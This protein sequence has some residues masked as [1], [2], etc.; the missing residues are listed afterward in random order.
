MAL[1]GRSFA[2]VAAV[3]IAVGVLPAQSVATTIGAVAAAPAAAALAPS[4]PGAFV[5]VAPQRL[6]DTRKGV[7]GSGPVVKSGTVH[8]QVTGR[9][10]VPATGVS[11][12]VMNVTVTAPSGSGYITAYPDGTSLPTASNLNF[13]KGQTVPNLV[14]VKVGTNGKVALRN[15]SGGT[16][17]LIAD[18]AGYYLDGA[19]SV[20]GAFVA[21]APQRLLDTRKGVGGS[22]PVVKSGTVHLQVTGRGGVPA[23]GVSAVVMNVT[24]TAPSGSGYITAYPD[25]TSLP[26]ASNL[27]FVKGQTVPNLVTVKVGTN[28]KVALR[29]GSGGTVQ[30][31]A[32]VAGYY[33]DGAPSVPGAFVAVAPQRLLD[34]RKGVGGSGPVVKSGTVHLQVT[35]RGGVP[36]TG[37]SAV[38]MNVTVTAPSGSGYITAYPDGTSLPTASNLNF[39]KGQTVPNLVTVKVGTNGKVAL[40]NGSGGT[41]QLIADV[42]GYYLD[43]VVADTTAPG[44]V[45][46]VTVT[47][48]TSSTVALSWTNPAD[49][50]LQAVMVRRATG[51]TAPTSP[52]AGTLVADVPKGTT[53]L[54][55]TA[56]S[57]ATQYSYA[58][59]A[60]DAVPNYATAASKTVS[61]AAAADTTPPAPVTSVTVT[62]T[63]STSV[64]M[65]WT[66]PADTD[67]Q[68]VMVRRATGA[69]A[70]TSPT[71]GTLVADVPK[72]TTTLTDTALSPATQ[73]SY[74]FFAHDA[75]PN[76]AS[77]VTKSATTTAVADTT[78][79]GP[80]TTVTLTGTTSSSVSLSWTNPADA[81][82]QAVMVRRATGATA[83][84]SPTAGTLVADVPK[85]TT[86]LT[87]T[88]LSPATPYSYAFFAHDAVPNYA[89]PVAKTATTTT[90]GCDPT[91]IH[92]GGSLA[93]DTT[94]AASQPCGVVYVLD[95]D[96]TIE[97]EVTLTINQGGIVKAATDSMLTVAGS[98]V[99]NGTEA[100]PVVFTSLLDDSVGGD[101]NGDGGAT[102]PAAGAWYGIYVP[103]GGVFSIDHADLRFGQIY[104]NQVGVSS[105]THSRVQHVAGTAISV[106]TTV[107]VTV[108]SNTV[109]DVGSGISVRQ[110][111]DAR[112]VASS[113]TTVTDNV[114]DGVH[115]GSGIV[116]GVAPVLLGGSVLTNLPA[117]TVTGNVV[118]GSSGTAISVAALNLL[119]SRLVGNTG[120]A[121]TVNALELRGTLRDDLTLPVDGLQIVIGQGNQSATG[122]LIVGEGVTL[123]AQAGTVL[124]ARPESSP[125][126][127]SM[128]TV[129]GSLVVNGTEADPVVFTS[130]LDD[131][132]G[133]DTNGDG[134][135][136]VPAAGAWYGIYVPDG[137]VFSID[138][139]D[140][141]FGQ[142]YGNQVGVSS[143]TH[144]RVQHVAGTAISVS[145]TVAVTVSS[146]T[147][148]DVGS[149]ISVRQD[150]DARDV[151]SSTT[152][153]TDNLVDGASGTGIF[154]SAAP[155]PDSSAALK[156]VPAPTVTG[157][158]VRNNTGSY[159]RTSYFQGVAMAVYATNL[160]PS[161]LT[162]NTGTG[163]TVNVLMLAGTL[164][165]DMALPVAGLP[166]VIGPGYQR[167]ST[168][169][170]RG[171]AVAEGVTLTVNAGAVLKVAP[172]PDSYHANL[173]SVQGSLVADGTS[174]DPVVFTSL[175]DD[176][177]GGD[178]N[179]D[180]GATSPGLGNWDG[181]SV[182]SGGSA[183]LSNAELTYAATGLSVSSGYASFHGRVRDCLVGVR[184]D[185]SYVDATE[186]DWG[187]PSGP[188]PYG[189]GLVV[190]GLGVNVVPWIGYVPAPRPATAPAQSVPEGNASTCARITV[191][192]LRGS[193][194]RPQ[195]IW[196]PLLENRW[197]RP[198]FADESDG[199]GT[200]S[201][202]FGTNSRDVSQAFDRR[203]AELVLGD[204]NI[205]HV[206]V[207][208]MGL[209]VPVVS[210]VG[211]TVVTPDDFMDSIF[212]GVDKL[213]ARML[214]ESIDCPTTKFVLVG[215]SQ[216]ALVIH[217]TLRQLLQTS[218]DLLDQVVGVGLIADP[219]RVSF[220]QETLWD[221]AGHPA[222]LSVSALSGIWSS[223]LAFDS[224]LA[225]G[226]PAT[227][228]GRT[229]SICHNFDLVCA[230][231]PFASA[232]PH[233]VYSSSEMTAMGEWLAERAALQ[234]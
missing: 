108:S 59:F 11:A 127:S 27:N 10:G 130:L 176:S 28:G 207:A 25:G 155:S 82:L 110:D 203:F 65:S 121:N 78:P 90:P 62:G 85:G 79:P 180:G 199:Y 88:A 117:P 156:D 112:D 56:L 183:E 209:A 36:A 2:L 194:E 22:G 167:N 230:Q 174:A 123:T 217:Y 24:V 141:R 131:S 67:L 196:T 213:N 81:D 86:T 35:G 185:G 193:G 152:T 205:K 42:A 191:L 138:H 105:L 29:N 195:A 63:T 16:V 51:A 172:N 215:Y 192:G 54:T 41:V 44:P 55:D 73:Y 214:R 96:T 6:L 165:A 97:A 228:Q 223:A 128:L 107:A 139:A 220:G 216:G 234:S 14:T 224:G 7:G 225:G 91:V 45:T 101:T 212:D 182:S 162:G 37:V 103:D 43:P 173:L 99:V 114:V 94:W 151:A 157:N 206:G 100:D 149:G 13:V 154:V 227:V 46:A 106:S 40:R 84:T 53:T 143:L 150:G 31:I 34:T 93:T 119:P 132:V 170:A 18:V 70:P 21:V 177:V 137:G 77:G 115:S 50:D 126:Y 229:I 219:G 208:Y 202:G 159:D 160:L 20:P 87:D 190:E 12:V 142:I 161:R 134:G 95:A 201:D 19:P 210:L 9:G 145:T 200:E 187:S 231:Q 146:N 76:Y 135:A 222:S 39:V 74:A 211:G 98:L 23:T 72:G 147:V 221:G 109:S 5:A 124:K 57:P 136:T 175:L 184:S 186:V 71:A 129:A 60:H 158:T 8:L 204:P 80:V 49:A 168:N 233:L 38:V 1:R 83:P 189:N 148:S 69:T 61:T 163:N 179:G 226:L 113:T 89:T 166:V 47:A 218:P 26:T 198:V 4:V 188:A 181:I 169:P 153:V 133:G 140:L 66:N 75:V 32:D 58:F 102:V 104:G 33:L 68:A 171:L 3:V 232:L 144:S 125:S 164:R 30:L 111:G 92:V 178:T 122:G 120:S 116:V 15:G 118:N 64:S 48:T 197:Q 17:Q 52:T